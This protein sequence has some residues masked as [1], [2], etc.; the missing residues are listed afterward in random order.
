MTMLRVPAG[1]FEAR[2]RT[3]LAGRTRRIVT[4]TRAASDRRSLSFSARARDL[5]G[6]RG[7]SLTFV[8]VG[9]VRSVV[10]TTG[11]GDGP[12]PGDGGGPWTVSGALAI[13]LGPAALDARNETVSAPPAFAAA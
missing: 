12:G 4:V 3:R 13:G 5:A 6:L 7:E 1:R 10:T 9:A 2:R 11:G 8:T